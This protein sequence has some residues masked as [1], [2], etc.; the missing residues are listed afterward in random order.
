MFAVRKKLKPHFYFDM[1]GLPAKDAA[2][3]IAAYKDPDAQ[4]DGVSAHTGG[5]YFKPVK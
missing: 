4:S 3:I 5:L 1:R 2:R